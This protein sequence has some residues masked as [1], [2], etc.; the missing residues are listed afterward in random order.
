MSDQ[1]VKWEGMEILQL[2]R[3]FRLHPVKPV[4]YLR[5]LLNAG[6]PKHQQRSLN[7]VKFKVRLLKKECYRRWL[8]EREG[9]MPTAPASS[10][11]SLLSDKYA[12]SAPEMGIFIPLHPLE[13]D[14]PS[15][16]NMYPEE[17]GLVDET[18]ELAQDDRRVEDEEAFRCHMISLQ[19]RSSSP[20]GAE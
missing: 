20:E 14:R 13:N 3:I 5:T 19:I 17:V 1:R 12:W 11:T 2:K 18:P 4:S 8:K 7:A 16:S 6:K 9:I 15:L 10:A